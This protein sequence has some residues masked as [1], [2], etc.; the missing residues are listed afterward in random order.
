MHCVRPNRSVSSARALS[1][2]AFLNAIEADRGLPREQ[3]DEPDLV[4]H[5]RDIGRLEA[6][7]AVPARPH[8]FTTRTYPRGYRTHRVGYVERAV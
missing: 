3:P 4:T 5:A 2:R 1:A 6:P 8:T 7:E